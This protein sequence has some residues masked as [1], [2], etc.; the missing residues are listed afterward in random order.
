M[1]LIVLVPFAHAT[2]YTV[3]NNGDPGIG[4]S[5]NCMVGNTNTCTLRDAIAAAVGGND[6]IV[7]SGDMTIVLVS[8]TPLDISFR[9][10]TI[11][12]MDRSVA[13]DGNHA[14]TVLTIGSSVTVQIKHL[15]IQH[16]AAHVGGGVINYGILNLSNCVLSDNSSL[17]FGGAIRNDNLGTL[18][19]IDS[20]I[21]G[22]STG[23]GGGAIDNSGKLTLS[24]STLSGNSSGAIGGG[25]DNGGTLTMTGS[26]LSGNS[27]GDGGGFFNN[28]TLTLV[29][30][31]LSG[32][33]A[34]I[35]GGGLFN[36]G[37]LTLINSTLSRNT[38][39][40]SGG[41]ISSLIPPLVINSIVATNTQAYGSDIDSDI[42]PNS[43]GNLMGADPKL[44]PL[45]N[46]GGPT[47]TLL[48][49]P[50]S[51]AI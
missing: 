5:S 8:N 49:F 26:T 46:N 28:G 33:G 18:T 51:V 45:Q 9:N 25:I 41:G 6:T 7:F 44:G 29:N 39:G 16:G 40:N 37:T 36:M 47:E 20:V 48:P 31:T 38:A 3:N 17:S 21:S 4:T 32:N 13:I 50:G 2:T 30:S 24:N 35:L 43:T 27:A 23:G 42:D 22:N 10:V 12:A 19:V 1:L 15:T 34:E 14:V 11:D